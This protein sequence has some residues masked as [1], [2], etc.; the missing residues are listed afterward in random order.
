MQNHE[1]MRFISMDITAE[2][3]DAIRNPSL[4]VREFD[5]PEEAGEH[6][7]WLALYFLQKG[8]EMHWTYACEAARFNAI[9]SELEFYIDLMELHQRPPAQP[10][11]FYREVWQHKKGLPEHCMGLILF[12]CSEHRMKSFLDQIANTPVP[13]YGTLMIVEGDVKEWRKRVAAQGFHLDV[14]A[15]PSEEDP[16]I[17]EGCDAEEPSRFELKPGL[18]HQD[19]DSVLCIDCAEA[20]LGRQFQWEDFDNTPLNVWVHHAIFWRE[21]GENLTQSPLSRIAG[22]APPVGC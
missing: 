6:D 2:Q 22:L 14:V 13:L 1:L 20:R 3:I 11:E 17:C 7:C 15:A 4:W 10:F 19:A 5:N 16:R 9:A 18:L 12:G 8:M 21:R